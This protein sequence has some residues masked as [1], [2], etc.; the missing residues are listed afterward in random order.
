MR[1]VEKRS[2]LWI[3]VLIVVG[4]LVWF[5]WVYASTEQYSCRIWDLQPP[6]Y[7]DGIINTVNKWKGPVRLDQLQVFSR[8]DLEIAVTLLKR[9]CCQQWL[10]AEN[11]CEGQ[12]EWP[13]YQPRSGY[14]VDHLM[15]VGMTK[16]DGDIEVCEAL[17]LDGCDMASAKLDAEPVKRREEIR[18]IAKDTKWYSA[19]QILRLYE[20]YRWDKKATWPDTD[21]S[22]V[23]WYI[24]MCDEID[25][26]S[27]ISF[28]TNTALDAKERCKD[29]MRLRYEQERAY[30]QTLMVEKW[31][32]Y[33]GNMMRDYLK[34]Y[35]ADQRLGGLV[36]KYGVLDACWRM[37]LKTVD[38]TPCCNE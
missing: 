25:E 10:L 31:S 8:R 23:K 9:S 28:A 32:Q 7:A 15:F 30:V 36:T 11:Y 29:R 33:L 3:G 21:G 34:E 19:E 2:N 14:L 18:K 27:K 1:I 13:N 37:V 16:F 6:K 35:F 17:G 5:Q 12:T 26:I 38:P 4:V 20:L 24:R 22:M